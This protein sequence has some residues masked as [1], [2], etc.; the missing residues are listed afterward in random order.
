M[1]R[2][3]KEILVFE[4]IDRMANHIIGRWTDISEKAI[5]KKG[6]FSVALSGGSTP[7]TLYQKLSERKSLPW[8]KTHIFMVDERFVPYESQDNNYH[9]INRT[10]LCHVVI[11]ANNIH[12]I[13]TTEITP[14]GSALRYEDNLLSYSKKTKALCPMIDLVLLG[15]GNDGHTAS[16]F[17][18]S[19]ALE[20]AKRLAVAATAPDTTN[21]ERIT[22]TYE[23][24]NNA[25]NIFFL[26]TG[27]NKAGAVKDII[28]DNESQLPAAKVKPKSGNIFYMLDKDSAS[29]LSGNR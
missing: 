26:A 12:F 22:I 23:V 19:P 1:V 17:P 14:E 27:K 29:L 3:N 9:M 7:L 21:K 20:E 16:L 4:S 11:P 5:E 18:G 10:M 28:E 24:I 15:I 13:S 2:D 25:K 8:G 6:H